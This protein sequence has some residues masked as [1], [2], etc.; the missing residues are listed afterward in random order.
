MP[1]ILNSILCDLIARLPTGIVSISEALRVGALYNSQ[2]NLYRIRASCVSVRGF[3]TFL[4][5]LRGKK[6]LVVRRDRHEE[7]LQLVSSGR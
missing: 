3:P 2:S 4:K 5:L 7:L 1:G 6:Q